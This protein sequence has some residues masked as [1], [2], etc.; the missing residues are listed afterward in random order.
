[1]ESLVQA[2]QVQRA[3]ALLRSNSALFAEIKGQLEHS[4]HKITWTLGTIDA[5]N[6]IQEHIPHVEKSVSSSLY[7]AALSG[8]LRSSSII[9]EILSF[10]KKAPSNVVV[11]LLPLIS[12]HLMGMPPTTEAISPD[13]YRDLQEQLQVLVE[14]SSATDGILRSEHDIKHETLRTTIVAQR[15]ELS[16]KKSKLSKDDSEYSKL[17]V[18]FHDLLESYFQLA[19]TPAHDLFLHE[20]LFYD[21]KSAHREAFEPRPRFA[22]ERALS[23]PHDYLGC[24]CCQSAGVCLLLLLKV[25]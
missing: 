21:L 20:I 13:D 14:E 7:T 11:S 15:V 22:I 1:M 5:I 23:S 6:L 10:V 3:K 12:D 16:S 9:Q 2:K 8:K 25:S 18:A 24:N 4:Q 17:V 19:I